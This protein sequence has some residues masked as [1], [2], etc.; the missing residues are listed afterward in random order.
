[1]VEIFKQLLS[2]D[3]TPHGFCYLWDPRIVWLHVI[4]DALITLS[5]YCI[6]VVL[7][8][9]IRK[10]RDL[11]FNRIFWM[12]GT[13]ILACGTTHL[14]EIWNVWHG[15]YLVGGVIKAITAAVSVVTAAMLIPLVPKVIS[16]PSRMHLQEVNR[17]LEREIAEH[18]L[19]DA[20]VESPLR[21]RITIGF[22]LAVLL[23]VFMGFLTWRTRQLASKEA[24]LVVH[25]YAVIGTLDVTLQHVIEGETSARGFALTGQAPLLAHYEASKGA[26]AQDVNTLRH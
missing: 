4:S 16:V 12:F 8:Y 3:F 7:I 15:S 17:K 6:P 19:I 24:D 21:R 26:A 25:T 5:Y 1:M 18:N 9:F 2:P 10:N 23:T 14:M 13:F 20:A 22:V 11:P